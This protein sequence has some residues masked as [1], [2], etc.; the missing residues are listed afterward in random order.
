MRKALITGIAGQDGT[1]LAELLLAKGYA[2]Y[3][4]IRPGGAEPASGKVRL[5]NASLLDAR[6]IDRAI[7]RI[8]PDEIYNLAGQSSLLVA[9]SAPL[10]TGEVT[11]LGAARL[12]DAILRLSP[13]T[14][15]FQ[16]SSAEM[17]GRPARS[18]QN[19]TTPLLPRSPYGAAKA[20]AHFLTGYYREAHGLFAASG[21]C[22]N[23]ESPRRDERF[24]MRKIAR[25]A[26]S[27]KLGLSKK[28]SIGN[29]KA[30]RDWGF[31]GDF[32]DAMW[33]MLQAK[34]AEDFVIATGVT[35]SVAELLEAA[36]SE[37][38]LDWREH[39]VVDRTQLRP[40][41]TATRLRGDARKARRKLGW[42][43]RVGFRE[44]VAMMVR[45]DLELLS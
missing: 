27:V 17:Y 32:A 42:R 18:P 37:V 44:L 14:R 5:V 12:L 10:L 9:T 13:K 8:K 34:K 22:F 35:H 23:H 40:G 15:Y 2:V 3:G 19:E 11:A 38:G 1:Y 30:R 31:A 24:V 41:E 43:P 16:A 39:V 26:A 36:F 45:S 25:G 4:M 7:A 6:S 21:I 33:R 20:H 28:I 29:L